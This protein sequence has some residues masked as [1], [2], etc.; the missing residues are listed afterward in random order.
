MKEFMF[1]MFLSDGFKSDKQSGDP[2][3]SCLFAAGSPT[4]TIGSQSLR[5]FSTHQIAFSVS[6][7]RLLP[8]LLLLL[9]LQSDGDVEADHT[10]SGIFM[11]CVD[12]ND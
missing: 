5:T 7:R 4:D 8:A 10:D 9:L 6:E 12:R 2:N 1:S 3:G 11:G